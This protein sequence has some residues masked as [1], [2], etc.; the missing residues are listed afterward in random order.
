MFLKL[1]EDELH[2]SRTK[3]GDMRSVHEGLGIIE[4]EFW[5]VKQEIFKS[6]HDKAALGKELVQLAAMCM[7]LYYD[8]GLN[9]NQ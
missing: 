9:A 2:R 6:K 1:V 8:M 7:K 5:E 3:H 4:E